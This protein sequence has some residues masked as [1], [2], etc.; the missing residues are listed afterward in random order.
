VWLHFEEPAYAEEAVQ[1][2]HGALYEGRPTVVRMGYWLA[3]GSD[4]LSEEEI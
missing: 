3:A 1:E 4:V 2:W